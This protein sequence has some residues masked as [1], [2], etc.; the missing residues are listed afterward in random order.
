MRAAILTLARP[1]YDDDVPGLLEVGLPPPSARRFPSFRDRD[2]AFIDLRSSH[3]DL[4]RAIYGTAVPTI[5]EVVGKCMV[6]SNFIPLGAVMTYFEPDRFDGEY[7]Q[8]IHAG[9]NW[10]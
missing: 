9:K 7:G 1:Q 4:F 6:D 3:L 10:L 5:D 8:R 2:F